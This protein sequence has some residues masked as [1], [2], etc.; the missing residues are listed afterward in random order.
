MNRPLLPALLLAA[1]GSASC[2][3]LSGHFFDVNS[4]RVSTLGEGAYRY[5][6]T[7]D[8]QMYWWEVSF[9]D[10]E[11]TPDWLSGEEPPL[12][13]SKAIQLAER[14]VPKYTSIPAAYRLEQ[15]EWMHIGNHIDDVRKWIYLVTFEREYQYRG[16][17]F[18]ARGTLRIPVL[19]DGRVIQGKK[20]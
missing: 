20:E 10:V 14:E 15:V 6:A 2:N 16:R 1:L 13:V 9:A 4:T 11:K 19:L 7:T 5:G 18:D 17:T 3:Y 12:S 8:G